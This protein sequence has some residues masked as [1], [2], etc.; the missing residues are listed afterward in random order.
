MNPIT[1]ALSELKFRIPKPILEKAFLPKKT[2]GGLHHKTPVSLDY[3]IR[4]AVIDARVMV[5]AQVRGRFVA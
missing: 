2:W 3:R 5:G 1:K 4:E